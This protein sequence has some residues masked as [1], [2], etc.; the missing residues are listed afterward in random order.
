MQSTPAPRHTPLLSP[1]LRGAIAA[2][3]LAV[4][5]GALI[6]V[7]ARGDDG[8]A[9]GPT[10]AGAPTRTAT[11][12]PE[13][14]LGP[15]DG[16]APL[17]GQPAPDFALRDLDGAVVKLSD[18]RGKVVWINFW[19]TWCRPCKKELPDIQAL[20]DEYP[21]DLAVLAINWQESADDAR[22]YFEDNNLTMRVLLDRSGGVFDQY[23]LTG[24]PNS[25]FIDRAGTLAAF[26]W[27]PLT[28]SKMRERLAQAGLQ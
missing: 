1:L 28:E 26:Q 17:I 15:M 12:P 5:A 14:D 25:F 9:A 2:A 7:R 24:L 10:L 23:R 13:I 21:D 18:L 6:F 4:I 20:S 11:E 16:R 8:G 27:G 19:A 22:A 3:L